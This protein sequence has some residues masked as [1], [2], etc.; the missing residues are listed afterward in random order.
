[1][2]S[3]HLYNK[4]NS[5]FRY[6][7]RHVGKKR[8]RSIDKLP[9]PIESEGERRYESCVDSVALLTICSIIGGCNCSKEG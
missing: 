9:Q 5:Y 7:Q 3:I 4:R 1:M 2:V 6:V 8:E